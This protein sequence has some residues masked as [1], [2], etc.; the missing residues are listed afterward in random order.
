MAARRQATAAATL[1]FLLLLS[2]SAASSS[3]ALPTTAASRKVL[4]WKLSCPWDAVKF[5]A[6]VGVLG[7]AGL[8]A[9]AQLGSKCCDVVQGLA[10]AEAAACFC[11]TVK[12]TVLGIPTEW[13]VGV[14]V[15]AS[16]C[17]TEL[18]NGFKCL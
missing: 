9:G 1:A 7:A 13:D 18:P 6:C 10:A 2:V 12:E 17:K 15:L 3:P 8:Q 5:G 16:A 4:H 11:T 14:G